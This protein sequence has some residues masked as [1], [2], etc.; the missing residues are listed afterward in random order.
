MQVVGL[1]R[2][3]TT[4]TTSTKSSPGVGED[5]EG[6]RVVGWVAPDFHVH[7]IFLFD[8]NVCLSRRGVL[9][10]LSVG[11]NGEGVEAW[12]KIMDVTTRRRVRDRR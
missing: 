12:G 10:S 11:S 2:S 6:E 1:I 5:R 4:L 9:L 8:L 7:V 3:C